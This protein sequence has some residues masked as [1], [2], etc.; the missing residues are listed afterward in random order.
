LFAI[1]V[2]PANNGRALFMLRDHGLLT[3]R[4]GV[5]VTHA[6]LHDIT[7]NPHQFRFVQ[8]D[9]LMQQRTYQDVDAAFLFALYAKRARL[10]PVRDALALESLSADTTE[11][12]GVAGRLRKPSDQGVLPAEIWRC[13]RVS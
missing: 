8:V 10:D 1:P 6:S 13:D 3:L 5:Q 9:Q 4:P 11:D 12:R 7:A 2:D